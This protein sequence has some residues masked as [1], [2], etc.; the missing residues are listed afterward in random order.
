[1]ITTI[2][3]ISLIKENNGWDSNY[4]VAKEL[5]ITQ[6][7]MS[8]LANKRRFFTDD[9]AHRVAELSGK[10]V[11]WVLANI[12]AEKAYRANRTDLKQVWEQVAKSV[13]ACFVG[14]FLLA[15]APQGGQNGA[16]S[17]GV[18]TGNNIHYANKRRRDVAGMDRAAIPA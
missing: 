11:A 5:G 15:G 16:P 7:H 18:N 1:M 4:R 3:L 12:Q 8:H 14:G 6:Q 2:E 17:N 13:A 9:Q 10:P